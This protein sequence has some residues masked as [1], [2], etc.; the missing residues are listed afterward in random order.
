MTRLPFLLLGLVGAVL[1]ASIA[2]QLDNGTV[3]DPISAIGRPALPAAAVPPG[4]P[5]GD[6]VATGERVATILA[7]PLFSPDRRPPA[8]IAGDPS[9][10]GAEPPRLAGILVQRAERRAIFAG[11]EE[12]RPLVLREGDRLGPFT[13]QEITPAQ[14]TVLGPAGPRVLRPSFDGSTAAARPAGPATGTEMPFVRLPTPSGMDILRNAARLAPPQEGAPPPGTDQLG[15]AAP[16]P[17][18]SGR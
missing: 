2:H 11:V 16:R 9:S 15:G 14:V 12:G 8:S 7:R 13:V 5:V 3:R 17:S 6:A 1:A 18:G 10:G 4:T